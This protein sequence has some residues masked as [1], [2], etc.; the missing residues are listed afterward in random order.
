MGPSSLSPKR[1]TVSV[2]YIALL[3]GILNMKSAVKL[4]QQFLQQFI[5]YVFAVFKY[6]TKFS[7]SHQ[8]SVQGKRT[9]LVSYKGC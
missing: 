8:I 9:M 5:Q 3:L 6:R 2:I 1:G 4:L 7:N